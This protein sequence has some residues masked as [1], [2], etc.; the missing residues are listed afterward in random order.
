V[1][2][3]QCASYDRLHSKGSYLYRW[4]GTLYE[5]VIGSIGIVR[6]FKAWGCDSLLVVIDHV[7]MR[8]INQ[9]GMLMDRSY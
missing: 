6:H 5:W 4:V 7:A 2:S 3:P 1:L 8:I 9:G